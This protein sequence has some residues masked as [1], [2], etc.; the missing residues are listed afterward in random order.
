[1]CHLRAIRKNVCVLPWNNAIWVKL[2]NY[3]VITRSNRTKHTLHVCLHADILYPADH[4]KAK[5]TDTG[6]CGFVLS[7][8]STLG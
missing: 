2:G 7:Y 3:S 4:I 6:I 8:Q 5:M 1:M